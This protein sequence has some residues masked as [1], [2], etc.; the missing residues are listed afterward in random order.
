MWISKSRHLKRG[1]W[2][3]ILLSNVA[4]VAWFA[5]LMQALDMRDKTDFVATA[6]AMH[7]G[8]VY[9]FEGVSGEMATLQAKTY[10]NDLSDKSGFAF[11]REAQIEASSDAAA[12]RVSV[13]ISFTMPTRYLRYFGFPTWPVVSAS[14]VQMN[15]SEQISIPT[16]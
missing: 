3:A 4:S 15:F 10:I 5:D 1:L 8:Q 12:G 13:N 7:G 14:S 16:T 6:A 2:A 9:R 11:L